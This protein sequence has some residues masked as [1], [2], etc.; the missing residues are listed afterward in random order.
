MLPAKILRQLEQMQILITSSHLRSRK[1]TMRLMKLHYVFN[2][3]RTVSNDQLR[4]QLYRR[5]AKTIDCMTR[6]LGM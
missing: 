4:N 2:E 3:S 1:V 6:D 5:S